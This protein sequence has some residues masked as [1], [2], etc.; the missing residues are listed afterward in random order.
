MKKFQK[1]ASIWRESCRYLGTAGAVALAY[2]VLAKLGLQLASVHPSASPIWA[3]TGFALAV[4]L[5]GGPRLWPA[6]FIGAFAA[7]ATTAGTLETSLLIALGN[8]LEAVVGG[9]LIGHW[10]GGADTFASPG[11]VV[12]FALISLGPATI[13]SATVGVITLCVTGFAAWTDFMAVWLTWW[14]GDAAGA[15]VVTPVIVLWTRSS[16][17]GSRLLETVAVVLCAVVVGLVAFSPLLPQSDYTSPLGFLAIL[18]LLWAALRCGPRE[19]ATI[20]LILTAFA[21]WGRIADAGPFGEMNRNESFLLLLSFMISAAVPTLV[22]SADVTARRQSD[23][24]LRE[25]K[26]ELDRRVKERTAALA[27]ANIH[28]SEAQRLAHL[29]SWSWDVA[30][31]RVTWSDGLYGIYGIAPE[32]FGGT[33]DAFVAFIH[34]QD[35]PTVQ[36]SINAAIASGGH[37][38]HEERI[39]RPD[40]SIRHLHSTGEV[41]RDKSGAAARMLGVCLDVTDRKQAEVA[42]LDSEHST[43]ILLEGVRDYAIVMMD[44]D[45]HVRSWN[46]GAAAIKGYADTEI[47]G[48]HFSRFYPAEDRMAGVPDRA[49]E[50][51]ARE[52]KTE[53]Q[54]WLLRKDGSRFYANVVIDAI[55]DKDG[56]LVGFAKITRDITTQREAEVA[57]EQTREQLAQA[58]KMEALGQL[59]GGIAHDFNNLL[60]IVSG[61]AQI[62]QRRLKEPKDMQAVE[63]IRAATG[64]GEKLTRQLLA[65]SRRQQLT[66]VVVDLRQRID[67]VRDMLA[68]SLRGNIALVCD[69]EANIWPVEVDLGEL[70]L[71]L[72]NVAV[73]ARDA[74]PDGGTITLQARNVVLKSGSAAG[75]LEGDFVAIAIIDGGTGIAPD[76]LTRVFEPFF[77]TKPVGKGTGLG[78]SQVHGFANQ[79]G[80]A[81]TVTSEAG[82]GTVVTIYLPRSSAVTP[83]QSVA[84]MQADS[85]ATQGTVLVVEDSRDVADV[86]SALLEQLGYRVVRA[87]NAAEALRHL[88]QGIEFDLVFSDIVMPGA[89]DGLGLAQICRERFPNIPVLLASGFSDAAQA[90]DGRFDIL[91]KPFELSALERAIETVRSAQAAA[92]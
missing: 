70:E 9:L 64:R 7:N 22:L 17:S 38:T 8:T 40:G 18:P 14:L 86:T 20:A 67:A 53:L 78:L 73:N 87:E 15:L 5:L 2:F 52:G 82:K 76:L 63:A 80:G 79:S 50:A 88:Q 91:R 56:Q 49:L 19:T 77:T 68:P 81:V 34:P 1:D 83:A 25:T 37:F 23:D 32:S 36:A 28:L 45:G 85:D 65:F 58:Q 26:L 51:A 46:A 74:M 42:L 35:R 41:I 44:A 6:V 92:K 55:Y 3:P 11:R 71:A 61:Y 48:Q 39:V 27:D 57:L 16:W 29:G 31:N 47:I 89:L 59:T 90:A 62:L 24:H 21:V 75:A 84:D 30:S 72:V 43:R 33:L 66:P 12:K 10:S 54:G 69:I 60:M 13:I 4:V